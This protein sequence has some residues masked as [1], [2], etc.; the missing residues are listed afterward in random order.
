M[1]NLLFP[2]AL[3]FGFGRYAELYKSAYT[4]SVLLFLAVKKDAQP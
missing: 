4:I 2:K 3:L 1:F